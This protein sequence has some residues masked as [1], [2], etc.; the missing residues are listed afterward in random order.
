[1]NIAAVPV[2]GGRCFHN[3]SA[4]QRRGDRAE[5]STQPEASDTRPSEA[6]RQGEI[7]DA[8]PPV[9]LYVQ[10]IR[11]AREVLGY[12]GLLRQLAAVLND[13]SS[14]SELPQTTAGV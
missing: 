14:E 8:F 2:G 11:S 10:Y 4:A 5:A 13:A 9:L 6:G 1:M 7:I 12:C 3:T